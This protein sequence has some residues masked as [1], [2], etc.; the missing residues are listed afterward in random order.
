[1][2]SATEVAQVGKRLEIRRWTF[3]DHSWAVQTAK[4]KD[5]AIGPG[6]MVNSIEYL[7]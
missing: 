4:T 5:Q 7:L 6:D 3:Q 1:M 2:V